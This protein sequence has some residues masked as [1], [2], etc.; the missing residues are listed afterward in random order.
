ML[1]AV[2]SIIEY[3]VLCQMDAGIKHYQEL[4]NKQVNEDTYIN[5]KKMTCP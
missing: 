5:C 3:S 4:C 2:R 1:V